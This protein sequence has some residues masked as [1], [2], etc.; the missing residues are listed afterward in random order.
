VN[1]ETQLQPLELDAPN[2][3]F[4]AFFLARYDSL[5]IAGGSVR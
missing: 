4:D 2:D 3:D 5:P 1:H